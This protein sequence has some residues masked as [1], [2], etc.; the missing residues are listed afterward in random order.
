[1]RSHAE[2]QRFQVDTAAIDG[3]QLVTVLFQV[4]REDIVY[5][6]RDTD[7]RRYHGKQGAHPF[8][9]LAA[10][11]GLAALFHNVI[12]KQMSGVFLKAVPSPSGILSD[13]R[14]WRFFLTAGHTGI[15]NLR[16]V[17]YVSR[18]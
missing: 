2:S 5:I 9:V 11:I 4:G 8:V 1:M 3:I 14:G 10:D 6:A 17:G 15:G 7:G 16:F 18:F 12:I 13:D